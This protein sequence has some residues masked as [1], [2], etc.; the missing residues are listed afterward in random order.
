MPR[1]PAPL[2]P[3]VRAALRRITARIPLESAVS[4]R[5][6]RWVEAQGGYFLKLNPPP[7]GIPDRLLILPGGAVALVEVKAPGQQPTP[8][9]R[10]WLERLTGCGV[11]VLV[12]RRLGDLK[13][14]VEAL[15]GGR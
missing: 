9:Q 8:L 11:P 5:C 12:C 4:A 15:S 6:R 13:A 2:P 1:R 14:F 7:K 10:E 3:A